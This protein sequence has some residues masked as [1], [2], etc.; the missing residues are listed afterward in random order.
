MKR[1]LIIIFSCFSLPIMAQQITYQEWKAAAKEEIRLLPKYGGAKKT[2]AQLESDENFKTTTLT[3]E[4]DRRKASDYLIKR[5]FDFYYK[6]DLKTAMFRFNQAWLIDPTNENVN[7]AFGAIYAFFNDYENTLKQYDEGL[8]LNPKSSNIL[9][10]KATVFATKYSNGRNKK[11]L[12]T[13]L[14]LYKQSYLIDSENQN[15]LFKIS[16]LYFLIDDCANAKRYFNE[17][18]KLGG[19]PIPADYD[20][21]LKSKCK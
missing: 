2:P 7:W 19:K 17:C 20:V 21:A 16:A 14:S 13:A 8:K 5:G 10:D 11:D 12:D 6:G 4:P 9:T 15:T 3:N 18:K 1:I